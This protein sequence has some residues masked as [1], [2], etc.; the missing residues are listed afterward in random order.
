MAKELAIFGGEP[1]RTEPF[2][3]YNVIGQKEID[4]ATAVMESGVL[5]RYLGTWHEDFL[6]GPKVRLLE[7]KWAQM[8]DVA[9]SVSMNSAT[10][11]LYA[12]CAAAGFGPDDEVIVSP[13]TMSASAVAPVVNGATP[14]F[15]DIDP[16]SWCLCPTA[17]E[18]LINAKTK[19]IIVVHIFGG[20]ADM[21]AIMSLA[22][23]HKLTVIE[24]CAQAPLGECNG[25]KVGSIGHMG[26]FS[27]NYH[28]HIHCGEGGVVVT[29][30]DELAQRLRLVRNH[31]E[32]VVDR[33]PTHIDEKL[34]G[35]VGYNFRLGEIEAAITLSL[36]DRL[37]ALI[38]ERIENVHFL[39]KKL[40]DIPF[41]T[42]PEVRE[43]DT[44]CYYLHPLKF[45]QKVA[46]V[47]REQY[48]AAVKAELT[49][50]ELRMHEG[51]LIGAGYVRPLYKQSFYRSKMHPVIQG[52]S[53]QAETTYLD[54]SCP[55]CEEAHYSTV[56]THELMRP[57]MS[58]NDLDDVASAFLKVAENI[59]DLVK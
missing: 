46:G 51:V 58:E 38:E 23:K 27:L 15:C 24:D 2:P 8:F 45:D 42:M 52:A 53:E 20:S 21:D 30:S 19:G 47:D 13:Y 6:G 11:G 4:A 3:G 43:G 25:R 54:Q 48:V 7:E 56:I 32:A 34:S 28:K 14:V 17:L 5:S 37:P 16:D 59:K 9:H 18:R 33:M 31:S 44:H 29:N 40:R 12:A 57:G 36:L 1:V 49:P 10:S 41:L 39:E 26:V 22:Q 55:N 50:S 35:I